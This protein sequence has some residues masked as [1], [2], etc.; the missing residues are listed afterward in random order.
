[1]RSS[2]VK[3]QGGVVRLFSFLFL[4]LVLST[5][6]LAGVFTPKVIYGNDDRSDVYE[7]KNASL[8]ALADAT[9][10]M[11][12]ASKLKLNAQGRYDYDKETFGQSYGTCD[13]EPFRDQPAAAVCSGFLVG[14]DLLATAGHCVDSEQ[15]CRANSWVFGY[16]MQDPKHAPDDFEADQVYRCKAVIKTEQSSRGQDYSLIRLDRPVRGARPLTLRKQGLLPVGEPLFVIGHPMGL[17]TK[18]AGGAKVR[19]WD[20]S[21]SF[22]V[23]NLDTYGG[24]SGSAVFNEKTLEVEGILVR[25][26]RDMVSSGGCSRSN[27]CAD[28]SCRGEDVTAISYIQKLI[29]P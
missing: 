14:D 18:V 2:R 3:H 29:T 21:K 27:T 28:G 26:E 5:T 11:F 9:A 12:P 6:A 15:D 17:P 1:M 7:T 24:N 22:F 16:R 25:G 23:A 4:G 19:R 13:D 10:G 20:T 8:V